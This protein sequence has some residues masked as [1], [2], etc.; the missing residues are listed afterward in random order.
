MA[1]SAVRMGAARTR[2]SGCP[3]A[4]ATPVQTTDA[5]RPPLGSGVQQPLP[6]SGNGAHSR[7]Q[8]LLAE[9]RDRLRSGTERPLNFQLPIF[10]GQKL[11]LVK[12]HVRTALRKLARDF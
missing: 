9:M 1:G 4:T 12:P 5:V 6:R 8:W 3:C 11:I 10:A 7:R 2:R